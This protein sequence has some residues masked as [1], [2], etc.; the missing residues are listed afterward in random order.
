MRCIFYKIFLQRWN[1][2]NKGDQIK[3]DQTKKTNIFQFIIKEFI[4]SKV[5][6]SSFE[7]SNYF[8]SCP[9]YALYTRE[10]KKIF[11]SMVIWKP[12]SCDFPR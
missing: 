3:S 5:R 4:Y 10:T 6:M 9:G 11:D 8:E 7:P 1:C 12:L 2:G